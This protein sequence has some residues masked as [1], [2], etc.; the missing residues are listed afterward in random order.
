M[1]HYVVEGDKKLHGTITTNSSKN[2]A[3]GL[4]FAALLNKGTTTLRH[5]PRIEEVNRIIEVLESIGVEILWQDGYTLTITP[6]KR[7]RFDKINYRAAIKTRSILFLLGTM[8]H[9]HRTFKMPRPGGCRLGERSV[10]P[11]LFALEEF[12]VKVGMAGK[13][14]EVT[15]RGLHNAENLVLY[16]AGDTVT[17][18]AI[19]AAALIPKKTVIKF[20][21][22]NYQIQDVCY[23]LQELGVR[24]DGIGST[25]LTIHG[26]A[27]IK[28]N[29]TYSVSEDPIESMLFI[30]IAATTNSTLTIKRCPIEFLEL[31]LLKLSKMGFKYDV[32]RRY[33]GRNGKT[34]LVDIKTH[35]S[36]LVALD[37]KIS[38]QPYP[39][40]N[41]DNLPFFAPIATQAKGRTFIF[42]WVYENRAVYFTELMKLGAN[43]TLVDA[44]R[45]FV[46]GPSRL[47]GNEI[48][49]PPA[50]RPAVIILVAMLAAQGESTLRNIYS[51]ERGYENL[52]D[53]L[54]S[55]GAH[56]QRV[57][58]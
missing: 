16:E 19:M 37:E 48:M 54:Q 8:I 49:S 46:S 9:F 5:V 38:A 35:P 11:H 26:K 55:I 1:P 43:V 40:L 51:I 22:A 17:E 36:N 12:G 42:D 20:A 3:M 34:K 15:S 50:L 24:I 45:I 23:F 57:E 25:T 6:P 52:C 58:D 30:S 27:S 33:T 56:I 4:L 7:Y 18:N 14:F 28:K 39:G 13:Y 29:I 41:I 47:K 31:E 32:L 10:Q 53:R 21:S 44:H 2:A